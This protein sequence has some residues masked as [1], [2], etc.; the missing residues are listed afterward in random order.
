[1][2]HFGRR[3]FGKS[4]L[5]GVAFLVSTPAW[6]G[7]YLFRAAILIDEAEREADLM[8]RRLH[9]RELGELLHAVALERVR[10]AGR[11]RVPEEVAK[12][13]PH[14]LLVLENCERALDAAVRGDAEG[15]LVPLARARTEIGTFRSVLKQLGW[16][17]PELSR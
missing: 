10:A 5:G 2:R 1:V 11:M 3:V 12:A 13:H 17:L 9:D 4:V 15:F 6:A 14:L 8:R 16:V 7:S